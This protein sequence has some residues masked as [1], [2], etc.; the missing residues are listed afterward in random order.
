MP[1]GVADEEEIGFLNRSSEEGKDDGRWE[2]VLLL[3]ELPFDASKPDNAPVRTRCGHVFGRSY[4]VE[5]L[6]RVNWLCPVCRTA[7][8]DGE[9]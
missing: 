2:N 8:V 4:L 6:E 5:S 3:R 7:L 1:F 9:A